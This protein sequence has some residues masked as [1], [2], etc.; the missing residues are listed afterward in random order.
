M[1]DKLSDTL[2]QV[3]VVSYDTGEV[4]RTLGPM[5]QH[6]A[7]RVDAGMQHNLDHEHYYTRVMEVPNGGQ[8]I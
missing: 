5:L 7:D 4:V 6:K 2:Y 1:T 8:T 3:E